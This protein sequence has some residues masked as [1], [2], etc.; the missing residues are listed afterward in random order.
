MRIK[1]KSLATFLI[2]LGVIVLA[3][4][5]L[6]LQTKNSGNPGISPDLAKCIGAHSQIYV[7]LGCSHCADQEAMFGENWKYINSTDCYY[8]PEKCNLAGIKYTPT[9]IISGKQYIGVQSV[10]ELKNLTEC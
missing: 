8:N 6:Y 9:W 2:I 5:I 7:Q 4:V 1:K 10:D 3:A